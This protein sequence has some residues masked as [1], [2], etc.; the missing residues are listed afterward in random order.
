M[1]DVPSWRNVRCF[2][3]NESERR[4]MGRPSIQTVCCLSVLV[5]AGCVSGLPGLDG[6]TP[7]ATPECK[8]PEHSDGGL[9]RCLIAERPPDLEYRNLDSTSH[10]LSV[11]IVRNDTSVDFSRTVILEPGS[12]EDPRI[13]RFEDVIDRSGHYTITATVDNTTTETLTRTFG[14]RWLGSGE[15]AEWGI[16]ITSS[17]ELKLEQIPH[18]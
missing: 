5:L 16:S 17:G 11:E 10:T 7:T 1:S 8:P 18:G 4:H 13:G 14:Q 12:E 15:G 9:P 3:T 6:G 2:T